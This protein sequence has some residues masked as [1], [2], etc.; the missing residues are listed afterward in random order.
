MMNTNPAHPARS[1]G[2]RILIVV[3]AVAMGAYI[4]ASV[5]ATVAVKTA[6]EYAIADDGTVCLDYIERS[7]RD[8]GRAVGD[9]L[10]LPNIAELDPTAGTPDTADTW[11]LDCIDGGGLVVTDTTG[12]DHGRMSDHDHAA[13]AGE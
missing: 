9:A 12:H 8:A 5:L 3:A 7:S 13:A 1:N 11:Q 4:V 6:P 10:R 2:A